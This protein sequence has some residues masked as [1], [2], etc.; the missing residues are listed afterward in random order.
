MFLQVSV[1]PQRG[2]GIPGC[3]AGPLPPDGEPPRWRTPPDGDPPRWRTPP[4]GEPPPRMQNPPR[5]GEPSPGQCA[6]GTH[7]TGMHSCFFSVIA[8]PKPV[9]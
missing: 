8:L 5:D 9:V 3:I 7:P 2:V 4:D 1:C 6:G